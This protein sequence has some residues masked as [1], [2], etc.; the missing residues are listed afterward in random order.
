M[1]KNK[2][3]NQTL[4]DQDDLLTAE[5]IVPDQSLVVIFSLPRGASTLFQQLVISSSDIG[6]ISNLVA[7]FWRAPYIAA[8]LDL[9]VRDPDYV[10]NFKSSYGNVVGAQEPH[11]WGWFWQHW[12]KLG[13]DE[14]YCKDK[15][16]IDGHGLRQKL[17]AL[18]SVWQRPL[19]IDSIFALANYAILADIMPNILAV[20]VKRDSYYVCNSH[21]NARIQRYGDLQEYY[22]HRPINIDEI[23]AIEDPIEQIVAQVKATETENK[24]TLDGIEVNH[25]FQVGYKELVHQPQRVMDDFVAFLEKENGTKISVRPL[26][27]LNLEFRDGA[28]FVNPK[29]KEKLD[30]YYE[31]YFGTKP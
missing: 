26:P 30:K 16:L 7:K 15:N 24:Q 25:I 20:N 27:K 10:S 5:V 17:G 29:F 28:E 8:Q 21:I 11:E 1:T 12:L 9:D 22:G 14:T 4:A 3:F 2:F 18:Q 6:Y 31:F 23:L 13:E 19:L